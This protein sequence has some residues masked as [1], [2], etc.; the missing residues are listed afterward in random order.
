[1]ELLNTEAALSTHRPSS[2]EGVALM[3]TSSCVERE[4]QVRGWHTQ[5][6]EGCDS[7]PHSA[8]PKGIS[9]LLVDGSSAGIVLGAKEKKVVLIADV[10]MSD[11]FLC[12]AGGLELSANTHCDV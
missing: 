2:V 1:M 10:S 11:W 9:C 3:C 12:I 7:C 5:A 8:G 6:E 4:G